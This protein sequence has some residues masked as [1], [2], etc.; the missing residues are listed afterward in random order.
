MTTPEF[1]AFCRLIRER[2]G[3]V[4]GPDKLYLVR[5]RLDPVAKGEGLADAQAVMLKIAKGGPEALVEKCVN[6]LAT[7]ESSFFRDTA[8]FAIMAETVLPGLMEARRNKRALRIW[9]AAC[10]SGQEPYSLA[11]VLQEMAPA[12]NGWR[13]EIVATDMSKP[14]LDRAKTGLYSEFEV[15]RGLSPERRARWL[16]AAE[17]NWRVSPVLQKMVTFRPHNL[18]AGSAGL[19]EFDIIL[20]RNVLIYFDVQQKRTVLTQLS[21]AMAPDGALFLGSAETI[22][23]LSDELEGAP[24]ARGL[25][26]R[27]AAI[28]PVARAV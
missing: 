18:L 4:I 19:G 11:M 16:T 5:S 15:R 1:D 2:S 22:M 28:Q 26:R 21:K 23:G 13:V 7:H 20:C 8:P 17:G 6:A 12:L 14:I 3:L 25:Y 9:C 10:S 27:R 24:G